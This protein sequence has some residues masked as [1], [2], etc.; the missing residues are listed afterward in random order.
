MASTETYVDAVLLNGQP[1]GH[2]NQALD[3]T[4]TLYLTGTGECQQYPL[5]D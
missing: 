5:K 3:T 2:P 1:T 4:C